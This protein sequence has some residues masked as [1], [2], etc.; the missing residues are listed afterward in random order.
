MTPSL[1]SCRTATRLQASSP[2]A[3]SSCTASRPARKPNGGHRKRLR[4]RC[5]HPL[6]PQAR[7]LSA[8]SAG[9]AGPSSIP[10]PRTA[11]AAPPRRT[12]PS[13]T[14]RPPAE[15]AAK[16]AARSRTCRSAWGARAVRVT[17][18]GH[19]GGG[20][21]G[22]EEGGAGGAR[23]RAGEPAAPPQD[24]EARGEEDC[25]RDEADERDDEEQ[26]G[27]GRARSEVGLS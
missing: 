1:S 20:R 16:T 17:A 7:A 9:S 11:P 12:S 13:R 23:G 27:H 24:G 6:P 26:T 8:P 2:A 15:R 5:P 21:A 22:G 3:I 10:A 18:G 19:R 4:L 25:A 14:A